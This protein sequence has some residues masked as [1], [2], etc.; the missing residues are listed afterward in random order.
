M[1]LGSVRFCLKLSVCS[2]ILGLFFNTASVANIWQFA[3][4]NFS[5]LST[6]DQAACCFTIIS[7]V[8]GIFASF[9]GA[10]ANV[11]DIGCLG[12][13]WVGILDRY[14]GYTLNFDV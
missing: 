13:Y 12:A 14:H 6:Q 4:G 2:N 8:F 11:F 7:V 3:L 9:A 10:F 5:N 1:T